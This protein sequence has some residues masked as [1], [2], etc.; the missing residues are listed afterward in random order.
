MALFITKDDHMRQKIDSKINEIYTQQKATQ[1]QQFTQWMNHLKTLVFDATIIAVADCQS[2][3]IEFVIKYT[4]KDETV[5]KERQHPENK[6]AVGFGG[7]VYHPELKEW[8]LH[9]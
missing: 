1:A 4:T 7:I 5:L 2:G 6:S 8:R 9:S 3:Q